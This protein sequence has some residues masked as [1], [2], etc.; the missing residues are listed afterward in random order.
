V[1]TLHVFENVDR[2]IATAHTHWFFLSRPG[3]LPERLISGD[4]EFWVRSFLTS[5]RPS[6]RPFDPAAFAEYVRCF[7]DPATIA[8]TCADYRAAATVDLDHDT[9]SRA[10][11]E[12]VRCPALVLWGEHGVVGRNNDVLGVWRRFATHVTG[13]SLPAGH[14]LA[15][16]APERTA[17]ALR[18]F[19]S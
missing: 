11:G 8:A 13:T 17:A 9:A 1:P 19:L 5:L 7:T 3:G 16:E 18:E 4:P 10:A 6:S 2:A 15:E 14:F 12:R